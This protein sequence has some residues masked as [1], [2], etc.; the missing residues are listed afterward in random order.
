ML[1]INIFITEVPDCFNRNN[2]RTIPSEETR[3]KIWSYCTSRKGGRCLSNWT[4]LKE[5]YWVYLKCQL[6]R[7]CRGEQKNY[8]RHRGCNCVLW[9]TKYCFTWKWRWENV[10]FQSVVETQGKIWPYHERTP[11]KRRSKDNVFIPTDPEQ[12][13]WNMWIYDSVKYC[14]S[15]Q[16]VFLLRLHGGRNHWCFHYGDNGPL[17]SILR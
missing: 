16:Q 7:F 5:R 15:M 12:A 14:Q 1:P 17:P 6:H 10:K 9:K 11:R 8:C 2:L 4:S 3:K 13:D